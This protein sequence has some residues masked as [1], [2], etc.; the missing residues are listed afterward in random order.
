[1]LLLLSIVYSQNVV[2][3]TATMNEEQETKIF[4][5]DSKPFG[6]SYEQWS[7]KWW[8]WVLSEPESS[9]PLVDKTGRSCSENQVGPIWFLAGTKGGLANR[10]CTIPAKKAIMVGP[11]SVECSY[12][13]ETPSTD[14]SQ[15]A[16]SSLQADVI[17]KGLTIDGS[18]IGNLDEFL[19]VSPVFDI[20]FPEN[21]VF[22]APAGPTKGVSAGYF[23]IIKPLTIGEHHIR[24]YGSIVDYTTQGTQSF[25][26]DTTYKINVVNVSQRNLS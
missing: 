14:L 9:N 20:T 2:R 23:V 15:C 22:G 18:T 10:E 24:F 21:S 25:A 8:Q 7:I 12:A 6:L 26:T 1:M 13:E 4:P 19:V 5:R 16:R 3:I 11:L 17:E